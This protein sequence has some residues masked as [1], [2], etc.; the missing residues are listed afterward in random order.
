[1]VNKIVSV[2]VWRNSPRQGVKNG[3]QNSQRELHPED[4]AVEDLICRIKAPLELCIPHY[5]EICWI[6][7]L[8]STDFSRLPPGT[9]LIFTDFASSMALR[10]FQTLNSS[11]DGHAVNDNFVCIYNQRKVKVKEKKKVNGIEVETEEELVIY[12]VDVLHFFAETMSKGK[13]N[14]HAM[15]NVALNAIITQYTDNGKMSAPLRHV[16]VWSDNA[17]TQYRCRQNFIQ[18]AS[19]KKRHPNVEIT[20]RFAV[21]HNFKG[22]HDSFGKDP[23]YKIKKLELEGTQSST[24]LMVFENCKKYLEKTCE[25]TKWKKFEEAGDAQLKRK[26]NYGMN[27]R[28]VFFVAETM[29]EYERLRAIYGDRI[30]LCDRTFILD[31]NK[32]KA[33]D[34]TTEFHEVRSTATNVPTEHPYVWPVTVSNLP[35]NCCHCIIDADNTRCK[36]APWRKTRSISIAVGCLPKEEAEQFLLSRVCRNIKKKLRFGTAVKYLPEKTKWLIK[37]DEKMEDGKDEVFLDYVDLCKGKQLIDS[38]AN[39][40]WQQKGVRN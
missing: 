27:S 8:Q 29:V 18:V 7:I 23:A 40:V 10:A 16:I 14:D 1:M 25:E 15:H 4:M 24:G 2:S 28:K 9:M 31:T 6:R 33:L 19:V 22:V 5:N 21:P 11:I 35:C 39:H 32:G 3:N 13:K 34:S 36:Y 20:H 38:V 12:D 26:G 17:P 37:L 30:L